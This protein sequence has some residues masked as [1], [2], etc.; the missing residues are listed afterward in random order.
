[1]VSRENKIIVGFIALTLLLL[2]PLNTAQP[3]L[4]VIS[5]VVL[6]VGVIAPTLINEYLDRQESA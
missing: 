3:P 2:V 1:M 6:G 4:W 5:A